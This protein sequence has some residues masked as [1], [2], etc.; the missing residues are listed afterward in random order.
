MRDMLQTR[1]IQM[2]FLIG[3]V[4]CQYEPEKFIDT[5]YEDPA[6]VTPP[7]ES[8]HPLNLDR[9]PCDP[10]LTLEP[11][12][13][14][15]AVNSSI[16]MLPNGG[17]GNYRF[18]LS[19]DASAVIDAPTGTLTITG[20][21]GEVVEATLTDAECLGTATATIEIGDTMTITPQTARV[22]PQTTVTYDLLPT[23]GPISCQLV[24]NNS[25]GVVNNCSYVA[26]ES[27]GIDIVQMT[28]EGSGETQIAYVLVEDSA[29]LRFWNESLYL[30]LNSQVRLQPIG[31][32]GHLEMD[33]P[34]AI[35]SLSEMNL[36]ANETGETALT[37]TDTYT[38]QSTT[39][40]VTVQDYTTHELG[41]DWVNVLGTENVLKL[42]YAPDD[43]S[44]SSVREEYQLGFLPIFFYRVDF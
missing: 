33:S 18:G 3:A 39:L 11:N 35:V 36:H 2:I 15:L 24:Q 26:G 8:D 30:P 22:P 28:D 13:L 12:G 16:L 6:M 9:P 7:L 34:S 27:N 43:A 17:S 32:S 14:T 42:T 4:A 23:I 5:A 19:N 1:I 38:G 20:N 37:F 41:I 31:G 40:L 44:E 25:G 21:V 10:P 29:E